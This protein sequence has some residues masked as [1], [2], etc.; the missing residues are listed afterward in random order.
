MLI[1]VRCKRKSYIELPDAGGSLDEVLSNPHKPSTRK[2]YGNTLH[3]YKA[4]LSELGA[5]IKVVR[6]GMFIVE[7]AIRQAKL[8][9]D[10]EEAKMKARG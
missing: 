1:R 8:A 6:D 4:R 7:G 5:D 3:D 10:I 9:R 2:R